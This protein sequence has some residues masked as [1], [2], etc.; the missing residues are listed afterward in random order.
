M[1]I[2]LPPPLEPMALF[3][4]IKATIFVEGKVL[5]SESLTTSIPSLYI[6]IFPS[7]FIKIMKWY[8]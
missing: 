2:I 5:A 4:L 8:H 1:C 7:V 6:S 3:A